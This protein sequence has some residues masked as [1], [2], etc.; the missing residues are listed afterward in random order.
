MA[1]IH[2]WFCLA[3]E[4]LFFLMYYTASHQSSVGKL[5]SCYRGKNLAPYTLCTT[6]NLSRELCS[7]VADDS[8]KDEYLFR[9]LFDIFSKVFLVL[10]Y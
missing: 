8:L 10:Q 1:R 3:L 5:G 4:F 2:I 7:T 9:V 6:E